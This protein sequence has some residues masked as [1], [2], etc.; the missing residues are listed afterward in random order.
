MLVVGG[1]FGPPSIGEALDRV[2]VSSCDRV[3]VWNGVAICT[4]FALLL[5][6]CGRRIAQLGYKAGLAERNER[7]LPN[8]RKQ[9]AVAQ[10]TKVLASSVFYRPALYLLGLIVILDN[11][12]TINTISW[13]GIVAKNR[14]LAGPDD[15]E[16][17]SSPMAIGVLARRI[18]MAA[19]VSGKIS[20]RKPPDIPMVCPC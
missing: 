12:A 20:D 1:I 17:L 18:F 13:L 15:I 3:D 19:F 6:V 4:L 10:I 7:S 16:E 5:L 11:L 8:A 2:P 14:F 9:D